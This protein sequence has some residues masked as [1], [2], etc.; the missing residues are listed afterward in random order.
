[1]TL[2]WLFLKS[3]IVTHDTPEKLSEKP[4]HERFESTVWD[5]WRSLRSS[6]IKAN[7]QAVMKF[8]ALL[9]TDPA[10]Q[11]LIRKPFAGYF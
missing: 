7:D 3:E 10:H 4:H 8:R 1:M 6:K 11:P 5:F 2:I 9:L